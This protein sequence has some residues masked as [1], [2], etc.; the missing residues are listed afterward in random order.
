MVELMIENH[1]DGHSFMLERLNN[2]IERI[3]ARKKEQS[4]YRLQGKF[5]EP[6]R[7]ED[8]DDEMKEFLGPTAAEQSRLI[9]KRTGEM[10]LALASG[11]NKDFHPE[12]FSLHYQ[13][14]LFS[15][16]LSLIRETY[17]SL[18]NKKQ[19]LPDHVQGEAHLISENR[20]MILNLMKRIYAR[21]LNILKIRT[22]G[23]FHLRQILLT[24]KDIAI[25]DFGGNPSRPY[26][27]RRLKRSAIRDIAGIIRSF[28][29]TAYEGFLTSTQIQKEELNNML[30]F[31]EI[32]AYHM[33]GFLL[34]AYFDAVQGSNVIPEAKEDLAMLI[35]TFVLESALFH[36][37]HEINN[38]PMWSIV[39]IKMIKRVL[40]NNQSDRVLLNE[41]IDSQKSEISSEFKVKNSNK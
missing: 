22:H 10:H 3:V 36:L 17:Q 32:W 26:S 37:S 18:S 21:K 14:S 15:S 27:E 11:I 12:E 19:I 9:G 8:L 13:R 2:Y 6:V 41:A 34:S 40:D 7:Y 33:S 5:S 39:P 1:G 29:Y 24:G 31:A 20:T 30:P 35:E 23:N 4:D 16:M 38:R 28:Y 25:H